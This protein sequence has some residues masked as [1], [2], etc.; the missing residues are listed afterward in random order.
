[1][2]RRVTRATSGCGTPSGGGVSTRRLRRASASRPTALRPCG[3]FRAGYAA[4]GRAAPR[5][6]GRGSR[7]A[8][9]PS[10]T[11]TTPPRR[12]ST[13]SILTPEQA[14][15]Y[16]LGADYLKRQ[17]ERFRRKP[18]TAAGR[19]IIDW[20]WREDMGSKWHSE[21]T[22]SLDTFGDRTRGRLYGFGRLPAPRDALVR[23]H[24]D[25]PERGRHRQK[26][27]GFHAVTRRHWPWRCI[28]CGG[29]RLR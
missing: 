29:C 27:D 7:C 5:Q 17:L 16:R 6:S 19:D 20:V 21:Q 9:R 28:S 24:H 8:C 2:P 10:P 26:R 1:M 15:T 23:L 14:V 3:A 22:S 13:T 4:R 18:I 25:R 11:S 12:R